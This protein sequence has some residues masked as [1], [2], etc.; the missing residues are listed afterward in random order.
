[1]SLLGRLGVK[2]TT[3]VQY[4][5]GPFI[6]MQKL[7]FLGLWDN[8]EMYGHRILHIESFMTIESENLVRISKF[9]I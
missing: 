2:A 6:N 9:F 4:G 8:C 3:Q 7:V 5:V 1:M